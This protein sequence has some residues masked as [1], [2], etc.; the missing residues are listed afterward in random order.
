MTFRSDRET[1]DNLGLQ[2]LVFRRFVPFKT[3]TSHLH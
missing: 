2:N 1:K 3:W